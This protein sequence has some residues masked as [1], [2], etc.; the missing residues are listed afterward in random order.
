MLLTFGIDSDILA[1]AA[2]GWPVYPD[3]HVYEGARRK[4]HCVYYTLG[5]IDDT[6]SLEKYYAHATTSKMKHTGKEFGREGQLDD[7]HGERC[8]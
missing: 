5:M 8:T 1:P 7:N 4:V 3:H 2:R 6:A